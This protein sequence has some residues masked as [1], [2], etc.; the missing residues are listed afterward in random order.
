MKP[1]Q[2]MLNF[3]WKKTSR[4]T[5][6]GEPP[7][8]QASSV[9]GGSFENVHRFKQKT[10]RPRSMYVETNSNFSQVS[11]SA[12][13]D[14][15]QFVDACVDP[16]EGYTQHCEADACR[17]DMPYRNVT[18]NKSESHLNSLA[19]GPAKFYNSPKI[20]ARYLSSAR[21]SGHSRS[22]SVYTNVYQGAS[23]RT[24]TKA[25]MEITPR[26]Y[27]KNPSNCNKVVPH[28]GGVANVSF[29]GSTTGSAH[30]DFQGSQWS[31]WEEGSSDPVPPPRKRRSK[32]QEAFSETSSQSS[33]DRGDISKLAPNVDETRRHSEGGS[34]SPVSM[35]YPMEFSLYL[36]PGFSNLGLDLLAAEFNTEEFNSDWKPGNQTH[37]NPEQCS[38]IQKVNTFKLEST[39]DPEI[40]R[41][42]ADHHLNCDSISSADDEDTNAD[43][44]ILPQTTK[45]RSETIVKS[46]FAKG[47]HCSRDRVLSSDSAET[48]EQTRLV[49]IDAGTSQDRHWEREQSHHILPKTLSECPDNAKNGFTKISEYQDS[50]VVVE[51]K[52]EKRA[53]WCNESSTDDVFY[54]PVSDETDWT[55]AFCSSGKIQP[56]CGNGAQPDVL[57]GTDQSAALSS[58]L[59]SL[60]SDCDESFGADQEDDKYVGN[61]YRL[62]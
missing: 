58:S 32:P 16:N 45:L 53:L 40:T 7:I 52:A 54:T 17:R 44:D 42:L 11:S 18:K 50:V 34:V 48:E 55:I 5:T 28:H 1:V 36:P 38:S 56:S 43:T 22:H 41:T 37:E 33:A 29:D 19:D 25:D 2:D 49:L 62:W 23:E 12:S 26:M 20:G 10:S 3:L 59:S 9:N 15:N 13:L 14:E 39:H 46:L 61:C 27:K 47:K 8:I 6:G 51:Q 4:K 21:N 57:I 24:A 30:S 31:F 60:P 35:Q